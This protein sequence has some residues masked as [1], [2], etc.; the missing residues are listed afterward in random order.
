VNDDARVA[1][2]AIEADALHVPLNL[3]DGH[4]KLDPIVSPLPPSLLQ[5]LASTPLKDLEERFLR[6]FGATCRGQLTREDV[7]FCPSASLAIDTV[8]KYLRRS[9]RTRVGLIE[10]A[11]DNL[12][13]LLVGEG[14][15]IFP[16]REDD[17]ALIQAAKNYDA[18]MLVIPNNPTGWCPSFSTLSTLRECARKYDCLII[19]DLTFR[20]FHKAQY[21][22]LV[23]GPGYVPNP[24][25]NWI[26]IDD[27][28]KTWSTLECKVA[29]LRCS[30]VKIFQILLEIAQEITLNVSPLSFYLTTETILAEG[31][32]ERATA[33]VAM[34]VSI[35]RNALGPLGY[36]D[37]WQGLPVMMLRFPSYIAPDASRARDLFERAGVAILPGSQFYW[38]DPKRGNG[39][40][41][42]ALMRPSGSFRL[43]VER[44]RQISERQEEW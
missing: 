1:L 39:S 11:F 12:M 17:E 24:G 36:Y 29:F 13:L 18:L 28:G 9:G 43:A 19:L 35:V 37:V 30:S 23:T 42:L 44:M 15:R 3:A 32:A 4:A 14:I 7:I 20:F 10:P 40:I 41:R 6:S 33:V 31:H 25:C 26:T 8:A 16:V 21:A 2:T 38:N 5:D 34:N 27:T 22:D